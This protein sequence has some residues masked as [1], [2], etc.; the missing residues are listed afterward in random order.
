MRRGLIRLLRS[1]DALFGRLITL[2]LPAVSQAQLR[3]RSPRSI[4]VIKLWAIG[5]SV[6]TLPA[7]QALR[8]QHP[9]ASLTLF[10]TRYVAPV[11]HR[12][13]GVRVVQGNFFTLACY[14][15]KKRHYFD[16]AVDFEP[17][18]YGSAIL[19][20]WLSVHPLG[21]DTGRRGRHYSQAIPYHDQQ[22]AAQ[23]Y[24]DLIAVPALA[25]KVSAL[26]PLSYEVADKQLV[27]NYLRS[28][29]VAGPLIALAPSV[30]HSAASRQW[31]AARFA[32]AADALAKLHGARVALIGCRQDQNLIKLI[33]QKI[34]R[35]SLVITHFSISQVAALLER[36]CLL[37]ANDSGLM[38]I[39]AAM[40]TPT[41]G[42]FGPN[43]PLR[44]RPLHPRARF[45]F[46]PCSTAPHINVHRGEISD[47]PCTCMQRISVKAVLDV[48]SAMLEPL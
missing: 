14:V 5:E 42:L 28:H 19:A 15:A 11:Y 30:G 45:I 10:T 1:S 26:L 23:T 43:L 22:H 18:L 25:A 33:A 24:L 13:P 2:C 47:E 39:G 40:G 48:A 27:D 29:G 16:M 21:F 37:I 36:C 38:H 34:Y 20:R 7:L 46:Q 35:P 44:F 6:L 12:Q 8:Q 9:Y 17:Y 32:Q 3:P 31:P 41:L 4:I